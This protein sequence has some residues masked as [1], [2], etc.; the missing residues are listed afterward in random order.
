MPEFFLIFGIV[1]IL[2]IF[3]FFSQNLVTSGQLL[4]LQMGHVSS[5][6]LSVTLLLY[7]NVSD[8]YVSIVNNIGDRNSL[9]FFF[10]ILVTLGSLLLLN[11]FFGYLS[12]NSLSEYEL[13]LVILLILLGSFCVIFSNNF[14]GLY[15]GIELQSLG[16]YV[17]ASIKI[18]STFA[19]EAGLKY[20]VLGAFASSLLIFGISLFYGAVGL[21]NFSDIT[22][23][24]VYGDL[25]AFVKSSIVL[26]LLFLFISLIFKVG[27]APFHM[28]VPD[29]YEG[30]PTIVTAFFSAIPKLSIFSVLIRFVYEVYSFFMVDLSLLLLLSG[31]LSVLIGSIGAI[32]QSNIKRVLSYSAVAHTGFILFGL[33]AGTFNSLVSVLFYVFIYLSLTL[34]LFSC[35]LGMQ[36]KDTCGPLKLV[37]NLSFVYKSN[38]WIALSFIFALFSIAGVPPLSGFFSKF[39]IF[40]TAINSGYLYVSLLIIILSVVSSVYYLKMIRSLVF[41]QKPRDWVLFFDVNCMHSYIISILFLFNLLFMFFGTSIYYYIVNISSYFII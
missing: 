40:V 35:I 36:Q 31:V 15:L 27:G 24:T 8:I 29:V 33:S 16:L 37:G 23:L 22:N 10:A 34:S 4:S 30:V 17:L 12:K 5:F 2:S 21:Y 20:F 7:L 1:T 41:L 39:Y 32:G 6:L 14:L 19:T 28:W 13:I 3:V 26:S 38:F 11:I 18:N 9:S 25:D